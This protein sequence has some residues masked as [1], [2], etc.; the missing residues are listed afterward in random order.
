MNIR[1]LSQC[2]VCGSPRRRRF[3][4]LPA[5]PLTDDFLPAER[6]GSE[7]RHDLDVFVCEDCL[8]AQTQHDV[9]MGEYYEDYQYA[10][11]ASPTASR[12]MRLVTGSLLDKYCEGRRGVKVLEVGSGDGGQLAAFKERGCEVLGYEPS[13]VLARAAEA[14]GIPTIQGLFTAGSVERLP[15]PFRQVDV[16]TLSYTFDHLPRPREFVAAAR[17]ILNPD[18]GLLFVEVHDLQK[19][20]D[21]QEFCLFEHEHTIYLTEAT[22]AALVA[23]EGMTVLDFNLVPETDRRANSL[24]FLATP[25]GSQLARRFPA[26]QPAVPADFSRLDFYAAQAERIQRGVAHLDA[27]VN[28]VTGAGKTLAGYGAGGRGVMTLAAMQTA[29]KFRYLVD[30]KPKRP[31]LVVP[32][33]GLPLVGLPALRDTPVDEILVFSFGYM[34][35]IQAELAGYGYQ[36]RQFHSLLDVLAGKADR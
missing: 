8:T 27:Y 33:C 3:L 9:E 5:M 22:A 6:F 2:R 30:K 19:I 24:L 4:H 31:G 23:R 28:R 25:A 13:S 10:V 15:A 17:S 26:P 35:E 16:V 29:S 12:F 32:K 36:P 11:G 21:R 1:L 7:F 34:Q 18:S 20:F 14:R